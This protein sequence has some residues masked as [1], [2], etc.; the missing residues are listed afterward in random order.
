M[1]EAISGLHH[2]KLKPNL[3]TSYYCVQMLLPELSQEAH[4]RITIIKVDEKFKPE[5]FPK[6]QHGYVNHALTKS[7]VSIKS[8][9]LTADG[10]IIERIAVQMVAMRQ[11]RRKIGVGPMRRDN[12]YHAS[13]ARDAMKLRHNGERIANMLDHVS[14]NNLVEPVI[15]ERIG[16]MI[17][18]IN[19]ISRGPRVDI[20][21]DSAGRLVCP[22]TD[23]KHTAT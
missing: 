21:T 8:K 17:Q 14:A 16:P 6:I 4:S 13:G 10:Q 19:N 7:R 15:R 23:V 1:I 18:V 3:L 9:D 2:F 22:A 11:V 5:G 20:R 12:L